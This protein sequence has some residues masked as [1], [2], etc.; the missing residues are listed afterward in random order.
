M[1]KLEVIAIDGV[2]GSGKS[3]TAKL[4]AKELGF[5]HLD[6]GAMYRML[7]YT[8]LQKGLKTD[9]H[10]A[11]GKVAESLEFSF[12]EKGEMRVNGEPLPS[13]IRGGEV[14]AHVSEY[15][16]PL[17]VRRVLAKQQRIL[18]LSRPCVAEGRDMT[19]V[20]FPDARWKFFMTARPEVRARRRVLELETLGHPADF[21]EI[22]GNLQDRDRKD[23][24]REHSPL[25][26]AGD[27]MEIDTSDFTLERQISIIADLVR[28]TP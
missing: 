15:C 23:S 17:E 5:S 21:E 20:V 19:T 7:T 9:Q 8:A 2:S 18:G 24:T 3:S 13:A 25:R 27:A 28:N 12:G 6:T 16:K 10:E 4:L 14:S 1:V 11:L 26:R 22:L